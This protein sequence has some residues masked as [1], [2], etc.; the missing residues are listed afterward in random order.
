MSVFTEEI[1][2]SFMYINTWGTLPYKMT[3]ENHHNSVT[4]QGEN[5]NNWWLMWIYLEICDILRVT[6]VD[7]F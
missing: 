5:G 1:D 4:L 7:I 2:L 6:V 3:H